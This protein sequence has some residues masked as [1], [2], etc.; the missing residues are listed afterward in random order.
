[1]LNK[2]KTFWRFYHDYKNK[3]YKQLL[4]QYEGL[5]DHWDLQ[6]Q[7]WEDISK[8]HNLEK[9]IIESIS[10]KEIEKNE[11]A[12]EYK[13]RSN[14]EYYQTQI[15]RLELTEGILLQITGEV[16][17]RDFGVYLYPEHYFREHGNLWVGKTIKY[18]ENLARKKCA[19]EISE[20]KVELM[21]KITLYS[22]KLN[23]IEELKQSLIK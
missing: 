5:K 8:K 23:N 11:A 18:Y 1:M 21:E 16:L 12:L 17:P 19:E 15:E 4:D 9:E 6:R 20:L 14:K 3:N 10:K 2:I 22:E 7:E 13:L